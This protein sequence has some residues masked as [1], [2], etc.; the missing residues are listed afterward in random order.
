MDERISFSHYIHAAPVS[1]ACSPSNAG[2]LTFRFSG[3]SDIVLFCQ[4][5]ELSID[6]HAAIAAVLAKH[7]AQPAT[8]ELEAA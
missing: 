8:C 1:V 4:S 5:A 7:A 6:L 2:S 3:G